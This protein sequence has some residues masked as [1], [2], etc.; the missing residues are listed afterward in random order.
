[1]LRLDRQ[2]LE[3]VE[4][5]LSLPDVA[6]LLTIEIAIDPVHRKARP[7]ALEDQARGASAEAHRVRALQPTAAFEAEGAARPREDLEELLV[8]L[9]PQHLGHLLFGEHLHRDQDLTVAHRLLRGFAARGFDD[10]GVGLAGSL[11]IATEGLSHQVRA[12]RYRISVAELHPLALLLVGEVERARRAQTVKVVEQRGKRNAVEGSRRA[13][14]P[15]RRFV[16]SLFRLDRPLRRAD[17]IAHHVEQL[18]EGH[19]LREEIESL[20][21][22]R[23]LGIGGRGR[24]A[25]Q[26]HHRQLAQ[27]ILALGVSDRVQHLEAI[28]AREH[29]VEEHQV[30]RVLPKDVESLVAVVTG[31]DHVA[32]ADES[33]GDDL[34]EVPIVVHVQDAGSHP[35]TPLPGSLHRPIPGST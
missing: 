6:P 16:A 28:T 34:T 13:T 22:V 25:G 30:R 20:Q 18:V 15:R 17:P 14:P 12:N 1:M 23:A 31:S 3:T 4:G 19:G 26:H 33:L 27:M 7:D 35:L 11:E 29:Q 10:A 8:G 5:R 2:I 24:R 32:L 9:L 21:R